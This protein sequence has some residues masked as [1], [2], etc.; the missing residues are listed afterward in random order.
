MPIYD[1]VYSDGTTTASGSVSN[2]VGLLNRTLGAGAGVQ[3]DVTAPTADPFTIYAWGAAFNAT[4]ALTATVGTASDTNS[5]LV[6]G[7]V[8]TPGKFYTINE[9]PDAAGQ[10]VNLSMVTT[11]PYRRFFQRLSGRRGRRG[12]RAFDPGIA[13]CRRHRSA[14]RR[15]AATERMA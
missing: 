11:N 13:R 9:V 8:R 5:S 1:F 3:V 10:V 2:P 12:A 15:A 14:G 7:G 6:Q 4:G